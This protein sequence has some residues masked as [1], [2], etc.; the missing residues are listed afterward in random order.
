M[1]TNFIGVLLPNSPSYTVNTGFSTQLYDAYGSQTITVQTGASLSLIGSMGA[2]TVRLSGNASA[3]QVYRDGST[4]IFVNT[5]GSRVELAATTTAQTLQFDNGMLDLRIHIADDTPKVV[6][7]NQTLGLAATAIEMLAGTPA[8]PDTPD[9]G[10][11]D[12]TPWTLVMHASTSPYNYLESS[13]GIFTSDGTATGTGLTILD[14]LGSPSNYYSHMGTRFI[15]NPDQ[16]KAFFYTLNS[17]SSG[18]NYTNYSVRYVGVTDGTATGT[19]KLLSAESDGD[20]PGN[21]ATIVD[22]QLILAGGTHNSLTTGKVV[23]SDGTVSGTTL[24]TTDFAVPGN[25][26]GRIEDTAHQTV[27]FFGNSTP[28]GRELMRFDYASDATTTTQMVK[29]IYPG[30][31]NSIDF[32]QN[33]TGAVLPNGKLVFKADDGTH[34]AE[35]WVS[36]GSNTGTFMLKDYHAGNYGYVYDFLAVGEKVA[37]VANEFNYFLDGA[38]YRPNAGTEL[39]ITDGTTAGTTL[40]DINPGTASSNP[41]ILGQA[42]NLIY[43]TATTGPYSA[44]ARGI[45]ST[46]GVTF[47]RLADINSNASLLGWDSSKAF[48]RVSDA[49]HGDE[50]WAADLV[51]GGFALV[52]DILPGSGSALANDYN[53]TAFMFSGQL[54]FSAYT[55]A[56]AQGF[57]LSDGTEAGTVQIAHHQPALTQVLGDTLVFADEVGLHGVNASS[58]TP[59]A[60]SLVTGALNY[61]SLQ[62]DTDQ[63]FF[64]LANGDLYASNGSTAGTVKLA[65]AVKNF[66]M[67]AEDAL[68]FIQ[69]TNTTDSTNQALWYSDGTETGTRFIED[70]PD[71]VYD[72]SNAV[73]ITTVGVG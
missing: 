62:A 61:S 2:N 69:S 8:E 70:L 31:S 68:F 67:V 59:E 37:F 29:D 16:S 30:S 71:G 22:N 21:F 7:G 18:P 49:A 46:D 36:D 52:K 13:G 15:T 56:T 63:V 9:G 57:F 45:F 17:Y 23:V 24:N 34:G 33:I 10:S 26:G 4:A 35:A 39:V 51:N 14:G 41:T 60:I 27:W 55:S 42:H 11:T 32:Y 3:W 50:L 58:P 53:T 38:E 28:Y 25:S 66:K 54:A 12:K 20:L 47:T 44:E 72:L 48:F 5:D 64:T 19:V 6:L 65:G 43:F 1:A 40:L 73:A